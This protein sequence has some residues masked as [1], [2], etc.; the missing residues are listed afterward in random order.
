MSTSFLLDRDLQRLAEKHGLSL[1]P[2]GDESAHDF[3]Y[4]IITSSSSH[5]FQGSPDRCS[6]FLKGLHYGKTAD[7]AVL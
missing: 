5:V 7:R 2:M 4:R 3:E 6:D 1:V